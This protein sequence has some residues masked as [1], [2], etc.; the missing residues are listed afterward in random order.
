MKTTILIFFAACTTIMA[1]AAWVKPNINDTGTDALAAALTAAPTAVD[2]FRI[3][4]I[5]NINKSTPAS[6]SA[7]REIADALAIKYGI[8]DAEKIDWIKTFLRGN[9]KLR[10]LVDEA[11]AFCVANPSAKNATFLISPPFCRKFTREQSYLESRRCLFEYNVSPATAL[12]LLKNLTNNIDCVGEKAAK[13]DF[14]RLNR[15]F[16]ALLVEDKAAWTPVV[17][18]IRTTLETF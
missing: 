12:R 15:Q 2:K 7:F 8:A 1:H 16:S 4:L 17:Q 13:A 10:H 3:E 9:K 18:I 6:L 5:Q 11:C 14:V